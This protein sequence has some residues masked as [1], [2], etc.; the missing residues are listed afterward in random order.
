MLTAGT[1]LRIYATNNLFTKVMVKFLIKIKT[2][3]VLQP[4]QSY[5]CWVNDVK[6]HLLPLIF[7]SLTS[8]L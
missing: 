7:T 2:I 5:L 1:C 3:I 8:M 4:V 6:T